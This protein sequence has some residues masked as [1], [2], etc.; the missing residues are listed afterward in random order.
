MPFM[1][2]NPKVAPNSNWAQARGTPAPS[3]RLEAGEFSEKTMRSSRHFQM[4][5]GVIGRWGWLL[6]VLIGIECAQATNLVSRVNGN[7][8]DT[9]TWIVD[10]TNGLRVPDVGDD[11]TISNTVTITDSVQKIVGSLLITNN[12]T[13]THSANSTA[14]V[15]RID[16]VVNNSLAV[17]G[18]GKIDVGSRGYSGGGTTQNGNGP[19]GGVGGST[20]RAGGGGHGGQ[21]GSALT[22]GGTIYDSFLTPTNIG[23]GG[24]GVS[25]TSGGAGGG[26]VRL[27]ASN[28]TVSGSI[29]ADGGVGGTSG[30][31]SGG[32]GS[33]GSIWLTATNLQITGTVRANGADGRRES[34][35]GNFGG[36]GGGGRIALDYGTATLGGTIQARGG[37]G[38]TNSSAGT[39]GAGTF[40]DSVAKWLCI[41]NGTTS[42][43]GTAGTWAT[44]PLLSALSLLTISNCGVLKHSAQ[45]PMDIAIPAIIIGTNGSINVSGLG[46]SG[47]AATQN[48]QGPG[49]GAGGSVLRAG[50][51]G[52]GGQ[53]GSAQTGGGA[54]NDSFVAPTNLGSGGGGVN[55]TSGGAGGGAVRLTASN[56]T[57][58]GSILADGSAGGTSGDNAGGGGSG[59]SIWLIA[60][61]LQVTGLLRA[62]GAD[63]RR[64][65]TFGNYGGAGGGGCIALDY[66]A[67]T[68]GGTIQA[69]GGWGVTNSSAGTGGAGTFYDSV[70]K[71]LRIDNGTTSMFGTAGTWATNP[72]LST[73]SLL[74]IS[75]CGILKHASQ[76]PMDIS[77]PTI[78]IGANGSINVS[79]LGYSGGVQVAGGGP[80]GGG[81]AGVTGGG[82]GH[83]GNG[84]ASSGGASGGNSNDYLTS[85]KR[86]LIP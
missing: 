59:G 60:T 14:E 4:V 82:G 74:T 18:T 24:G 41:D 52:H 68:L 25:V 62:N 19:G 77:V 79:G 8:G 15:Y 31:N 84:G 83:G 28:L 80:G 3:R 34:T 38:V 10:G 36:A 85:K 71:W 32:G 30:D 61:N 64:E 39:G 16:L 21:G 5:F 13:L 27:T 9:N 47:G 72:L 66:G 20:T 54:V 56:L 33:G 35:S 29:L 57:V 40:Y 65:S 37:F 51:G 69:Q 22:G 55:V 43:F 50:G 63:G 75:N 67:A 46:Y 7:W 42:M 26:A 58:N 45:V 53:G 78:I 70:S 76:V 1:V 73:L 23:S 81:A 6:A 2:D 11:V 86:E 49:G 48:G 44:N 17:V 12:G